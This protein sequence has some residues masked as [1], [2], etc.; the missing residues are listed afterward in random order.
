MEAVQWVLILGST[1]T[2]WRIHSS[3]PAVND[4]VDGLH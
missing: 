2:M 3:K 4:D 1:S